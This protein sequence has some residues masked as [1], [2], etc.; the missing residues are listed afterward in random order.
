MNTQKP[1]TKTKHPKLVLMLFLAVLIG[2]FLFAYVLVQKSQ[3]HQFRMSNHGDLI[4]P[5]RS[6]A[7]TTFYDLGKKEKFSSEKLAGKWWLVYVSPPKCQ[8]TCQDILYNMRQ[9]RTALGKDAPR[10]ERLFIAHPDCHLSVCEVYLG[11]SYPDMQRAQIKTKDFDILF[12]NISNISERESVGEMFIIDPNGNIMM[13]YSADMEAKA[14]L[15]DMKRLLK[16]S[17]IG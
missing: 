12:G 15:S 16:S 3:N 17:K 14:I 9:I 6:I 8:H 10:V 11:Q 5:V 13:H 2:P 7:K 1:E 4:I